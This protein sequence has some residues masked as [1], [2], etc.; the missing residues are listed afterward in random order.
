MKFLVLVFIGLLLSSL[1]AYADSDVYD[2]YLDASGMTTTVRATVDNQFNQFADEAKSNPALKAY[3]NDA[4]K[5]QLYKDQLEYVK[6]RYQKTF[7][8]TEMEYLLKLMQSSIGKKLMAMS[9]PEENPS[10]DR[11]MVKFNSEV[12][13][14]RKPSGGTK[15]ATVRPTSPLNT[16]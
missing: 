11:P 3:L 9:G 6:A 10:P 15:K 12:Q 7:N 1:S 14:L 13:A 2:K 5:E 8:V 16:H 4:R